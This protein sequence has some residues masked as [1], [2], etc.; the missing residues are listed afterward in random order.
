MKVCPT[1]Q[2]G[3]DDSTLFCE[4]CGSA[5]VEKQGNDSPEAEVDA[6]EYTAEETAAQPVTGTAK[7]KTKKKPMN[8]K[9]LLI[10]AA[11]VVAVVLLIV[12]ISSIAGGGSG[13]SSDPLSGKALGLYVKDGE[14]MFTKLSK[15]GEQ[16]TSKMAKEWD[17]SDIRSAASTIYSYTSFSEDGKLVFFPDRI[18][19]GFT[20][21][22][23]DL[24]N[25]KKDAVKIDSD[26]SS[27]EVN[28]KG[29]VVTYLKDDTLYQYT[30]SKDTKEKVASNV[31]TYYLTDD[32]KTIL[33]ITDDQDIYLLAAGKD[34]EKMGTG[35]IQYMSDDFKTIVYLDDETLCSK[36][37]GKD[38]VKIAKDVA[39]AMV[40][41]TNSMYLTFYD[42]DDGYSFSYYN[43]KKTVELL[44]DIPDII[45]IDGSRDAA[46]LV[47]TYLEDE[48]DDYEDAK[49][50]YI[51]A[52]K[53]TEI[54]LEVEELMNITLSADGKTIYY[55]GNYD[56]KHSSYEVWKLVMSGAK[57]KSNEMLTD[58]AES[59]NVYG[60]HYIWMTDLKN[61]VGTAYV[62]GVEIGSDVYSS[63]FNYHEDTDTIYF[64]D[65]YEK[66]SFTTYALCSVKGGK[67]TKIAED[68]YSV[69]MNLTEGVIYVFTDYDEDDAV[70]TL[71]CYKGGKLTKVADEVPTFSYAFTIA[72]NGNC[73]YLTE[74]SSKKYEGELWYFNGS[75]AKMLD[76]DVCVII[77]CKVN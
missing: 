13:N 40:Y 14:L 42:Y 49:T 44:K 54:S 28:S 9:L 39:S 64:R 57:V 43:G 55:T 68:V 21:Y 6:A 32:A 70:A 62:D 8:K 12:I 7:Q 18:S 72:P 51:S 16:I 11:A 67:V 45:D 75:K 24:G 20:L 47:I 71:N 52:D 4:S 59:F 37:A 27:Y 19:S 22:Y 58:E 5:L 31:S 76:E 30:I 2:Q 10:G 65:D 60:D 3:Y 35:S 48:D 77:P 41:D 66:G 33:Y 26:I 15:A 23:R 53:V 61:S 17:N 69:R 25:M 36:T 73:L 63:Y 56:S 34:K 46:V 50:V 29:T 1:C 74:Y 38:K